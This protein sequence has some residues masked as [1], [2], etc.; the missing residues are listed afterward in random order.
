M[1]RFSK[2]LLLFL[3]INI[4]S[5]TQ[6]PSFSLSHVIRRYYLH[7]RTAV[8][9]F[10][11]GRREP[12]PRTVLA[13]QSSQT[14]FIP[15]WECRRR[16]LKFPLPFRKVS[17]GSV[18]A[19]ALVWQQEVLGSVPCPYTHVGPTIPHPEP[20][21]PSAKL[22]AWSVHRGKEEIWTHPGMGRVQVDAESLWQNLVLT[23]EFWT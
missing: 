5:G 22:W 14:L 10:S 20:N 19:W 9:K 4:A 12:S 2:Y 16:I 3:L 23:V 17:A 11:F 8:S 7:H 6:F 21:R 18:G 15:S 13:P 1:S